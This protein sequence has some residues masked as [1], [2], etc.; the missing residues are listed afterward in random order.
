MVSGRITTVIIKEI[1]VFMLI[2]RYLLKISM[3][4]LFN[5]DLDLDVL[6]PQFWQRSSQTSA[7]AKAATRGRSGG[8]RYGAALSLDLKVEAESALTIVPCRE[9]HSGIVLAIVPFQRGECLSFP[10]TLSI[11]HLCERRVVVD[12][13]GFRSMESGEISNSP[14]R[15]L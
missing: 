4:M 11:F 13:A 15:T 10:T 12:A 3:A 7:S 6:R 9:F 14:F 1:N 8:V 2:F 5:M